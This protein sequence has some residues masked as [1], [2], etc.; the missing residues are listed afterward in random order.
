MDK[1]TFIKTG[2]LG[3]GALAMPRNSYAL[4]YYPLKSDKKWAIIYC[5]WCGSAR[6][7]GVWISEG[8]NGIANVFDVREKP[9]ISKFD[10]IVIGG[11]IRSAKVSTEL[12]TFI[13]ENQ[14]LLKGKLR[15][16][17]AVAGNRM[18]AFEPADKVALFD[19][20]LCKL[21]GITGLPTAAF[22]GRVTYGLMDEATQKIMKGMNMPEYDNLKRSECMAFGKELINK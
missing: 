14:D 8:M 21:C 15:G 17:F 9:D 1:R 18:K 4:E 20:Y 6:D 3:I 2:L 16:L 10:N 12:E 7:A 13:A 22:L 19:N 5:T 11:A